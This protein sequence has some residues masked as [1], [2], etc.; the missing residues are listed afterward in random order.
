MLKTKSKRELQYIS[1]EWVCERLGQP[2]VRW[3]VNPPHA[4]HFSGSWERKIFSVRRV[5]D[6]LMMTTAT[7]GLTRDVFRTLV[8]VPHNHT[9]LWAV[10]TDPNGPEP[11]Y[12]A[13]LLQ[14]QHAEGNGPIT[15]EQLTTEA[16]QHYGLTRYLVNRELA[17]NFWSAWQRDY[18]AQLSV[19]CKWIRSKWALS[20][21]AHLDLQVGD[22]V[23][24]RDESLQRNQWPTAKVAGVRVS[25]DGRVRSVDLILPPLS[26]RSGTRTTSRPISQTVLIL[27]ASSTEC[28]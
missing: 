12:P 15:C 8:R 11:L 18:V 2:K 7:K 4:S 13:M 1:S 9:P 25:E 5:F 27:P 14:Q 26:G 24:M 22:L 19:R 17:S 23:L 21:K 16:L 6:G 20:I 28:N 3:L 10:S